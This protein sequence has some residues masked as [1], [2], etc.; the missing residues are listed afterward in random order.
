MWGNRHIS[1]WV[2]LLHSFEE[3]L[4][5]PTLA[6]GSAPE[7]SSN[8]AVPWKLTSMLKEIS[9]RVPGAAVVEVS[10]EPMGGPRLEAG[11]SVLSTWLRRRGDLLVGK[12]EEERR[13]VEANHARPFV[14]IVDPLNVVQ[15]AVHFAQARGNSQ[16]VVK[17]PPDTPRV[18]HYIDLGS[19][20][21]RCVELEGGCTDLDEGILWA[22]PLVLNMRRASDPHR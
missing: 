7:S 15:T 18:N 4:H 20:A 5:S 16:A 8:D 19:N 21:S 3:Y 2:V 17:V 11:R 12:T 22:E 14:T 1:D 13:K 6:A 10:Q 9:S